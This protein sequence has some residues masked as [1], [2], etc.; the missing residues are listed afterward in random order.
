MINQR[1]SCIKNLSKYVTAFNYTDKIL[2]VLVATISEVYIISFASVAGA[3]A[4]IASE[5]LT[6]IFF[7]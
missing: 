6:L 4:G 2:I 5:S 3:P 7:L 1:K